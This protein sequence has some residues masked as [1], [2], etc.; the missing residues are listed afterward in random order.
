MAKE[1]VRS[2]SVTQGSSGPNLPSKFND[3]TAID[4]D[5]TGGSCEGT[6]MSRTGWQTSPTWPPHTRCCRRGS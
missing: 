6:F 3:K 4:V 5:R 2:E 1:Y